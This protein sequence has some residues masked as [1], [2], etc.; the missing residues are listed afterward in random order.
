[1]HTQAQNPDIRIGLVTG[2]NAEA[3]QVESPSNGTAC[4]NITTV[5]DF[6]LEEF[7]SQPWFIQQQMETQYLPKSQNFCVRAKYSM[8]PDS[9]WR[10]FWGYKVQV[11]NVAQNA[12]GDVQDSGNTLC[13]GPDSSTDPAKLLVAPCFLPLSFGG[14]YW[15]IAYNST[16]GYAL[17][18][19]GQPTVRTESGC[20]TGSGVNDAGLWI[21]T[22][23]QERDESIV[24]KVRDIASSQGFD[25][26]VL[27]DVD[28]SNCA[29]SA[30]DVNS[31]TPSTESTLMTYASE[32]S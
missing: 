9:S 2:G 29:P 18:S 24:Q 3:L 27:N 10:R 31:Q 12:N 26:T 22:N 8:L 25:L 21:F 7:I 23:A 20:R 4:P 6:N 16:A 19:G 11:R 32:S 17:I 1:M 5:P 28:Q 30:A 13:A 15:V 14:P